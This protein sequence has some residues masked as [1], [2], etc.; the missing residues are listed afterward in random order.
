MEHEI[1]TKLNRLLSVPLEC[2]CEVV[3]L[4][5][6]IRKFL[7]RYPIAEH[8]QHWEL[9]LLICS[10]WELVRFQGIEPRRFRMTRGQT[11]C[12]KSGKA[13]GSQATIQQSLIDINV[14]YQQLPKNAPKIS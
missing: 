6:E 9:P 7:D 4:F 8:P 3:Y 10:H 14:V 5:V 1:L 2:E 12:L 11:V 13:Q